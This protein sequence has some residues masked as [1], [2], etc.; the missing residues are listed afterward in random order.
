MVSTDRFI[1]SSVLGASLVACYTVPF[2][3]LFRLLIIPGAISAVLFPRLTFVIATDRQ[4]AKRLYRKC[5][6]IVSTFMTAICLFTAIGSY[7]I[8][9]L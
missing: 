9:K 5:L 3:A 7:W 4:A 8:I 1:I 6:K 2:D